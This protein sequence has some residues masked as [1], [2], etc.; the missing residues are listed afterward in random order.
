MGGVEKNNKKKREKKQGPC[1]DSTIHTLPP[2]EPGGK[3]GEGRCRWGD[4]EGERAPCCYGEA[5]GSVVLSFCS[6][7]PP[8][9]WDRNGAAVGRRNARFA[10]LLPARFLK[11]IMIF[12]L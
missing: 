4:G 8:D 9:L 10:V 3:V 1:F 7:C 12:L 2:S 6:M 5:V 11:R